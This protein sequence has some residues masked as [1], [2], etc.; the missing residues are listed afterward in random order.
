[1]TAYSGFT[2]PDIMHDILEGTTQVTLKC[3]LNYLIKDK[4]CFSL[5][6]LNERISSFNYG[7][8]DNRN[9]PSEISKTTFSSS[10]TLKQSG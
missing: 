9:K 7:S 1:M 10:E 6:T 8:I 3:L 5:K 4:K 2:V